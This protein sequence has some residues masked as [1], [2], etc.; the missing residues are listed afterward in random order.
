M[1]SVRVSGLYPQYSSPTKNSYMSPPTPFM[2]GHATLKS[3]SVLVMRPLDNSAAV[4]L[5]IV[6]SSAG[7]VS[8]CIPALFVADSSASLAK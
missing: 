5:V 8:I 1:P 2:Y 6:L 4:M 7:I 3:G